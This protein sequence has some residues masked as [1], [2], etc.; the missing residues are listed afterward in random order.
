M[1]RLICFAKFIVKISLML[2]TVWIISSRLL[3]H[4][5]SCLSEYVLGELITVFYTPLLLFTVD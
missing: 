4:V 1:S 3:V 2:I 5:Y